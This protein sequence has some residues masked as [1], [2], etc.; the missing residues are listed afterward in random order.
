[1]HIC[2][3]GH[4]SVAEDYCD[5]C[6]RPIVPG[7]GEAVFPPGPVPVPDSRPPSSSGQPGALADRC[8][9]CATAY[10]PDDEFCEACGHWRHDVRI[11]VDD[12]PDPGPDPGPG[13][14]PGPG[15]QPGPGP[16]SGPNPNPPPPKPDIDPATAV[17][18]VRVIADHD[19]FM[20]V[21]DWDGPDAHSMRFPH[22]QDS[23]SIE[24]TD[25]PTRIGRGNAGVPSGSVEIAL[26]DPGVSRRHAKL[27]RCPDGSWEV[28]DLDS[29][30]GTTINA[31]YER[32]RRAPVHLKDGD[33]IHV[34]AWTTLEIR[35]LA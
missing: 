31:G 32:V 20:R 3:E 33:R 27:V 34:G 16:D 17:W 10:A 11:V 18:T 12:G 30:N 24:L 13:P 23:W 28:V 9:I 2:S 21:L 6:G 14:G 25:E 1:M 8:P 19:Y 4:Q 15:P 29:A 22:E 5:E 7:Y 26:A 35:R